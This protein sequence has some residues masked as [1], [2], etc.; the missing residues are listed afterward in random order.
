MKCEFCGEEVTVWWVMDDK[1][2]CKK[3]KE[4]DKSLSLTSLNTFI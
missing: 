2:C 1:W 3:C 4:K